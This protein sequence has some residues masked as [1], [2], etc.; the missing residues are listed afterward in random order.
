MQINVFTLY[1]VVS[2]YLVVAEDSLS[3]INRLRSALISNSQPRYSPRVRPV[4][5]YTTPTNVSVSFYVE[6]IDNW[7]LRSGTILMEG[8]IILTWRDEHLHW[9]PEAFDGLSQIFLATYE[10][11]VP[12]V[13]LWSS[14]D[15]EYINRFVDFTTPV[16]VNSSGHCEWW[17]LMKMSTHC[18]AKLNNFPFDENICIIK[19]GPNAHT[20]N[21]ILLDVKDHFFEA[22]W[23]D[24]ESNGF[25][26]PTIDNPEYHVSDK[27]VTTKIISEQDGTRWSLIWLTMTIQR[28]STLYSLYIGLP[29]ITGSLIQIIMFIS[30]HP[31]SPMRIILSSISLLLFFMAGMLITTVIGSGALHSNDAP[32]AIKC[33]GVNIFLVSMN[34]FLTQLFIIL[35]SNVKA[36][37]I[38]IDRLSIVWTNKY[39]HMIFCHLCVH[40]I[41][42]DESN[43]MSRPNRI[44]VVSDRMRI[45]DD[46]ISNDETT[47]EEEASSSAKQIEKS[48]P[49]SVSPVFVII[50]RLQLFVYIGVLIF[51][52]S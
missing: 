23:S 5:K 49:I 16:L 45:T 15:T 25:Y 13:S 32:Y 21:E 35:L 11:W 22:G 39:L 17:P 20:A 24:G 27:Q 18:T 43:E 26:G 38:L 28:R 52:H 37:N 9:D 31:N 30:T 1:L 36:S 29:Y 4:K 14:S 40:T 7:D 33:T 12:E 19:I 50:D 47:T 42:L 6:R 2:S 34:L 44:T 41:D 51:Y 8:E 3:T 10:V 48:Q 46:D